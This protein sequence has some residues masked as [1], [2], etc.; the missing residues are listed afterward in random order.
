MWILKIFYYNK[1]IRI[2]VAPDLLDIFD[3]MNSCD[4]KKVRF[5]KL[6][7]RGDQNE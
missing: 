5:F 1:G 6:K 4:Y 3:I 2:E 7:Y